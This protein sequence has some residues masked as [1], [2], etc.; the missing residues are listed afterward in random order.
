MADRE[1]DHLAPLLEEQRVAEGEAV[2]DLDLLGE[3]DPA[4]ER[5]VMRRSFC[6]TGFFFASSSVE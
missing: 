3:V 2:D 4:P 5:L 6:I 1:A